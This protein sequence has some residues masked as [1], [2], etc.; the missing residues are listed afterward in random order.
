MTIHKEFTNPANLETVGSVDRILLGLVNQPAQKRDQFISEELTNHLFQTPGFPFGMD[1]ASLNVQRGRDHGIAPYVDWRQPCSLSPIRD[2]NDLDRV[3]NPEVASKF[4]D[5]YAAVEDIDLFSAGLAEKPVADGLVGPTFACIIAQQF[6]SL[7]KGDRFW[8]ENPFL[9]SGFSPEQLQQIRRTTL[10]QI[11]CRT[12]DNIDNIQPFVMLAA[13]TL[14]NQRLDCK[15]SSLDQINLDAWIERP[16]RRESEEEVSEGRSGKAATGK[17]KQASGNSNAQRAPQIRPKPVKTRINQNNRITVKRPLGPHEN[18]TIIVNN[19]A[20]NAPVFVSD[21]I[22]GSNLQI[23]HFPSNSDPPQ[24][25]SYDSAH[26]TRPLP[27]TSQRP[28]ENHFPSPSPYYPHNFQDPNN[29]NPPSYGFTKPPS[30]NFPSNDFFSYNV[31]N[32]SGNI[33]SLGQ[34]N[35]GAGGQQDSYVTTKRPKLTTRPSLEQHN[36]FNTY[37]EPS[38]TTKKPRPSYNEPNVQ[39][40]NAEYEQDVT[41]PLDYQDE[42]RPTKKPKPPKRPTYSPGR[43]QV[44][45]YSDGNVGYQRPTRPSGYFSSTLGSSYGQG[46]GHSYDL[47][48]KEEVDQEMPH[49]LHT[50]TTVSNV[51]YVSSK[52]PHSSPQRQKVKEGVQ[53]P[54]PINS[55]LQTR[56]SSDGV[57]ANASTRVSTKRRKTTTTV[58]PTV[59]SDDSKRTTL[60]NKAEKNRNR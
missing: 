37:Q 59:A 19:N 58:A 57:N 42:Y 26:T 54:K 13:D 45:D 52:R 28:Y 3:M 6:R 12:L 21:S 9:E 32:L 33:P 4:R 53:L 55:N 48:Q 44:E 29:P 50:H 22:Y 24:R 41:K 31:P 2:W 35:Y 39:Y 30:N 38:F 23:N 27:P 1:L 15:D 49:Y 18:L 20:V 36:Y 25:P 60:K 7:R 47:H 5:I 10:A 46:N 16:Q 56:E 14:R 40:P 8:Y 43:P 51:Q 34:N 11:L 17:N